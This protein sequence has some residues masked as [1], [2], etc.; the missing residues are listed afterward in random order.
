M[1]QSSWRRVFDEAIK[2]FDAEERRR[3]FE[4]LERHAKVIEMV[5]SG[6]RI[7]YRSSRE[8]RNGHV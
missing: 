6:K 3:S 2:R 5:R 1:A 7:W 8:R 4:G